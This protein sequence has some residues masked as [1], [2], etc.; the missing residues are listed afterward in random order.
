MNTNEG[1]KYKCKG[2]DK[3][4]RICGEVLDRHAPRKK[5]YIRG[6][7]STLSHHKTL[8]KEITK[9]TKL[10]NNFL[11]TRSKENRKKY[12]KHRNFCVSLLRKAKQN[13]C[14]NLHKKSITDNRKFLKK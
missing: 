11:K 2:F 9:R 10:R 8:S 14:H 7:Q 13:Y 3:I 12:T 4:F 1:Y 5:I 6:N